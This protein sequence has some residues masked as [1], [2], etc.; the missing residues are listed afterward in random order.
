MPFSG[1]Q[2][3]SGTL[4]ANTAQAVTFGYSGGAAIRYAYVYVENT[5][6][7]G[8]I[9]ARADG[10]PA[11]VGG[12]DCIEIGPGLGATVANGAAYW[13]QAATVIPASNTGAAAY[14]GIAQTGNPPEVNPMGTS[15]YGQ[16]TDPGT[17]VSLI[18]SGTPTFTVTGTG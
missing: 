16:L 2:S 17:S 18:S 10:N 3:Y 11:T 5:G 9:F 15:P 1:Q 4:V 14:T 13:T 7:T 12:D 8:T 6:A